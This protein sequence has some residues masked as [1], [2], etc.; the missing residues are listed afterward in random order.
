MS[1]LDR[2]KK[3]VLGIYNLQSVV[4]DEI[5]TLLEECEGHHVDVADAY[6]AGYKAGFEAAWRLPR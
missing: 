1:A 6:N 5:E 4:I 2:L 3:Y